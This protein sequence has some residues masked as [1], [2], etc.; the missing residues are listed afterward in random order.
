MIKKIEVYIAE[1]DECDDKLDS[2]GDGGY[3]VFHG[4]IEAISAARNDD[5]IVT[6][7][8]TICCECVDER[9]EKP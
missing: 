1:C 5:W 2:Y 6:D 8:E 7:R 9:K 3:T 4:E